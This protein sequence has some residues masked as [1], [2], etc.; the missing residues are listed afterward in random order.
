MTCGDRSIPF[1]TFIQEFFRLYTRFV[2]HQTHLQTDPAE[3]LKQ[4]T[5]F[6]PTM[7]L[8]VP[9]LNIR[10]LLPLLQ[11][12]SIDQVFSIPADMVRL[13]WS[14]CEV[15]LAPLAKMVEKDS[16][17]RVHVSALQ[18]AT[19]RFK[20]TDP[21]DKIYAL[22]NITTSPSSLR[23]IIPDYAKS[24][25]AVFA[26]AM[27]LTL[28][29]NFQAAWMY[30]PLHLCRDCVPDLPSWVPNMAIDFVPKDAD[31][32]RELD[33]A[34]PDATNWPAHCPM[35]YLPSVGIMQD[36]LNH[37]STS[38]VHEEL[39]PHDTTTFS[40][41]CKVLNTVGSFMGKVIGILEIPHDPAIATN[42]ETPVSSLRDFFTAHNVSVQ[43]ALSTIFGS[44]GLPYTPTSMQ[45]I[46]FEILVNPSVSLEYVLTMPGGWGS[47]IEAV[48][49]RTLF[50]TDTGYVGKMAGGVVQG[51]VLVG[52]FGIMLPFVLRGG[53]E[54]W[55]MVNV[56]Y[57]ADHQ[58]GVFG[59][60]K[61]RFTIA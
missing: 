19:A 43:D 37:L 38:E 53:E 30:I 12:L 47:I 42:P 39:H 6:L 11:T 51:D 3:F 61:E 41:D 34:Y 49:G 44:P 46:A 59:G 60:G 15:L 20:A 55:R 22:V 18:L 5:H 7:D 48:V 35:Y 27:A 33:I 2:Y 1:Q 16:V 52:L 23:R 56:A 25:A 45:T 13:S 26:E 8:T 40:S 32:M 28:S 31:E 10:D 9:F 57:I 21:R 4:T 17:L 36:V 50:C 14:H 24:T 58:L 29:E 54:E